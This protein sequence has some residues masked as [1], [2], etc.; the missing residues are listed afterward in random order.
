MKAK[1]LGTVIS[2]SMIASALVGTA[3]VYA[4]EETKTV[5]VL[6]H[7]SWRTDEANAVFDYVAEKCGVEFEFE[8][9][10]EG[11]SGEE[12][13]FAKIQSGE[14]PDIL[15]FQGATAS[16]TNMGEEAFA[17]LSGDWTSN[18]S[19]SILQ[20]RW[21]TYNGKLYCAP[22]GDVSGFGM[23]YNKAVFEENGLEIPTTWDELNAACDVLK[24]AGIIPIY[25]SGAAGDEW[26]LQIAEIDSSA[27]QEFLNPGSFAALNAHEKN[28]TDLEYCEKVLEEQLSWVENGYTQDTFL[29]DSYADAQEALITG[30]AAMYPTAAFIYAE[31][32]SIAESEEELDNIGMFALPSDSADSA[33][34]Y[35]ESATGFLVPSAGENV[36]FA[37]EIVGELVSVDAMQ[38]Y[39]S[40]HIGIPAING[41]DVALNGVQADIYSYI[42]SG[43]SFA[44]PLQIY[45]VPSL[46]SSVQAMMAGDMTPK[47][48][49]E[50]LDADWDTYAKEAENPDWGY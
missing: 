40:N 4:D 24:A 8:E 19:D 47:E 6:C 3:P 46:A 15:W 31:L 1:L 22:F 36:D 34:M 42:E 38:V 27:K 10:P 25:G 33:I 32:A 14:V 41:V 49:L 17:E 7:S 48:V 26:T 28:W 45:S 2:V 21:Q 35:T 16:C 12:L 9:V 50:S 37:K 11:S 18:F 20:S 43:K 44:A 39:Y 30:E 23:A 13:I 5:H 29:S